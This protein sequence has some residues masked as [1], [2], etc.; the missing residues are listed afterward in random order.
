MTPVILSISIS[1]VFLAI[2][3]IIIFLVLIGGIPILLSRIFN[4]KI[5]SRTGVTL[6]EPHYAK[7]IAKNLSD[8]RKEAKKIVLNKIKSY[9]KNDYDLISEGTS[10]KLSKL[11]RLNDL[12]EKG[13]ITIEEFEILKSEIISQ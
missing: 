11:S 9:S 10:D 3:S 2:I 8:L 7:D 5:V 1:D 12:K 6:A 4:V 13:V